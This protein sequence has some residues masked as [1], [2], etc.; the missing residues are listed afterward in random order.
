MYA[1][2]RRCLHVKKMCVS[3]E[4]AR[5]DELALD[6]PAFLQS[7][8]MQSFQ[9]ALW[10]GVRRSSRAWSWPL[11]SPFQ[12]LGVIGAL[13]PYILGCAIRP[14]SKMHHRRSLNVGRTA[15]NIIVPGCTRGLRET[16]TLW[17]GGS[18]K[19]T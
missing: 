6:N 5:E 4:C 14:P 3:V 13:R 2:C 7:L 12:I 8:I 1:Y 17:S 15:G 9:C 11:L 10:L 18:T 19:F 16:T